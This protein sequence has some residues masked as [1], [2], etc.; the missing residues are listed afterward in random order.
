MKKLNW[1]GW[2]LQVRRLNSFCYSWLENISHCKKKLFLRLI[3]FLFFITVPKQIF[4]FKTVLMK[5]FRE[6][7]SPS[8]SP[9]HAYIIY[10]YKSCMHRTQSV[11]C[12]QTYFLG[13]LP[14]VRVLKVCEIYKENACVSLWFKKK[15]F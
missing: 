1:V 10:S 5:Q 7:E 8:T 15:I 2:Y 13:L 9:F 12:L 14:I 6:E 3:F 11:H 4:R